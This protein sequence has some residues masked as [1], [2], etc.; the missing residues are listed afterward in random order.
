MCY[1]EITRESIII[2]H[3]AGV[4][5]QQVLFSALSLVLFHLTG[6]K[7]N[8]WCCSQAQQQVLSRS[9]AGDL[10][11]PVDRDL[12]D[13]LETCSTAGVK[14]QLHIISFERREGTPDHTSNL[15]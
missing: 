9:C 2:S 6:V 4:S 11:Q 15:N 3:L 8:S 10:L 14:M 13:G 12:L 1:C 7:H 5:R